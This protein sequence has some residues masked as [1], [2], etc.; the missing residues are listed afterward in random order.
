MVRT[1]TPTEP[2]KVKSI[3][4]FADINKALPHMPDEMRNTVLNNPEVQAI[5][6]AR[7]VP[8]PHPE[9]GLLSKVLS[10]FGG[11]FGQGQTRPTTLPTALPEGVTEEDIQYT[12]KKRGLSREEVLSKLRR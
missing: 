12:M 9:Q 10:G 1:P 11:V 4:R 5:F 2:N 8:L 3:D 7:G 6:K